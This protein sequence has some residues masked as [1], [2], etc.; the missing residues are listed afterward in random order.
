MRSVLTLVAGTPEGASARHHLD[1]NTLARAAQALAAAGVRPDAPVWLDDGIACDLPFD[2]DDPLEPETRIAAALASLPI[3]H[4]L[5]SA[6]DRRKRLLVADMDSTIVIGETLDEVASEAGLGEAVARLSSASMRGEV[7]FAGSLR[8]RVAMLKGLEEA[9]LERTL[10]RTIVSPGAASLVATMGR[11]GART[12]LVSGGFRQFTGPIAAALGFDSDH[13]NELLVAEGRLTGALAEPILD[14]EAKRRFLME[15]AAERGIGPAETA[16]VGDGAN[17]LPMLLAAGLGVA[18]HGKP[19][20][21]ARARI[22]IDHSD[23]T[24]L[25]Y[26]QGYRGTE[27]VRP[28]EPSLRLLSLGPGEARPTGHRPGDRPGA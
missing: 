20:V 5:Q 2:G 21:A 11:H 4:A 25:L 19:I 18:Y 12:A 28:A 10:A 24:T 15:L 26:F 22:R 13:A 9:A 8:Q 7:D 16:A 17:D 23:L 6:A 27:F 1:D 14:A 3:D